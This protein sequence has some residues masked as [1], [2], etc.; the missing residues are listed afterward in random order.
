[1]PFVGAQEVCL[2]SSQVIHLRHELADAHA[3]TDRQLGT[4]KCQMA[5]M[6]NNISCLANRPAKCLRITPA[7]MSAPVIC[8]EEVVESAAPPSPVAPIFAAK[9][10]SCHRSLHDL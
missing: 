4:L 7:A 1:M 9:L 3:E 5:R 8:D 2:L 6:N 10:S